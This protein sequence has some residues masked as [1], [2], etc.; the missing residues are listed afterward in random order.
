VNLP[1]H[2][3]LSAINL[4]V[5]KGQVEDDGTISSAVLADVP[6]AGGSGSSKSFKVAWFTDAVGPL[7]TQTVQVPTSGCSV[8]WGDIIVGIVTDDYIQIADGVTSS[9]CTSG[10]GWKTVKLP[11]YDE[12]YRLQVLVRGPAGMKP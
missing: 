7:K 6:N 10:Y 3:H 9:G 8:D 12:A 1:E 4:I 5:L 11:T 2:F